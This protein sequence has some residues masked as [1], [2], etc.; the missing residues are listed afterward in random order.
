MWQWHIA[1]AITKI[2]NVA[3]PR[4]RRLVSGTISRT[5]GHWDVDKGDKSPRDHY[6][7]KGNPITPGTARPGNAPTTMMDKMRSITPGPILKLG[8]AG[9]VIYIIIDEGPRLSRRETLSRCRRGGMV[10][11][12]FF[13][14]NGSVRGVWNHDTT[15]ATNCFTGAYSYDHVNRLTGAIATPC[16][17]ATRTTT[18][19]TVTLRGTFQT[20]NTAT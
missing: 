1:L 18:S 15:V 16:A 19:P 2:A 6:D 10:S 13:F 7:P 5:D 20:G 8:T 17:W 12:T 9:V 4:G 11:G 14:R 3:L